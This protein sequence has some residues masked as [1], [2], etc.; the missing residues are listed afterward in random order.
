MKAFVTLAVFAVSSLS[1]GP[2]APVARTPVVQTKDSQ[3]ATTPSRALEILKEGNQRFADGRSIRRDLPAKA[4]MTE[5]AQY[6]FA[7]VVS[8]MD[9]R[10]PVEIAFDQ[11]IGDLFSLRVAGNIVDSD[12][13]GSL[14]YATNV[15]GSKLILV[16]GHSGCGAVKGAIDRV[17]LGNLT[18][19]LAKIEPAVTAA[20]PGTSKD[21]AYVAKVAERNVRLAMKQVRDGSPLI[22]ELLDKGTVA[23]AGGMYDLSTGKVTFYTD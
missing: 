17:K 1:I 19:L 8:C 9:S 18:G 14:E 6:P 7:V 3:A 22:K 11:T 5:A 12:F 21:S 16:L 4:K 15:V 2:E 10:V 23:L 20:G 13:L